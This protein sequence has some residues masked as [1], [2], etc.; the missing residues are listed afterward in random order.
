MISEGLSNGND[1]SPQENKFKFV[2][3]HDNVKAR[4]WLAPKQGGPGVAFFFDDKEN[5]WLLSFGWA[6]GKTLAPMQ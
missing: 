1:P 4:I 3:T 2:T 6:K 5:P